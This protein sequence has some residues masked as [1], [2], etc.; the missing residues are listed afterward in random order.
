MKDFK[1]KNELKKLLWFLQAVSGYDPKIRTTFFIFPKS[2]T[3]GD[4]L[5]W[6]RS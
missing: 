3:I 1:G 5:S 2:M 6:Y 4:T